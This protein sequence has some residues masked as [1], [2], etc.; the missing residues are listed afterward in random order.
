MSTEA[1]RI[2]VDG[3]GLVSGLLDTSPGAW[4]AYVFAHGAGA[5]MEHAFMARFAA[6]LGARGIASLRFQFP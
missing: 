1:I 2:T 4:A 5:G 6:A 3:H